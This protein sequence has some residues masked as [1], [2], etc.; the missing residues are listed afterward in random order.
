MITQRIIHK[1][2]AQDCDTEHVEDVNV[3]PTDLYGA[4]L[5]IPNPWAD[6]WRWVDGRHYCRR[7]DIKVTVD[8]TDRDEPRPEPR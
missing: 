1:C 8:V 4:H 7:H 5:M 3:H 2:D 6:G